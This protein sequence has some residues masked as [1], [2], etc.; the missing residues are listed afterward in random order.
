MAGMDIRD[1]STTTWGSAEGDCCVVHYLLLLYIGVA[2]WSSLLE[3]CPLPIDFDIFSFTFHFIGVSAFVP[4]LNGFAWHR[5]SPVSVLGMGGNVGKVRLLQN[6]LVMIP[7]LRRCAGTQLWGHFDRVRNV[8]PD[9]YFHQRALSFVYSA[10]LVCSK[11][12]V[13]TTG[14][15]GSS[16]ILRSSLSYRREGSVC[17]AGIQ[18]G[19]GVCWFRECHFYTVRT[20][21]GFFPIA[22]R[23]VRR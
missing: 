15:A 20:Q 18:I 1:L 5:T 22:R 4:V 7:P 11:G 12:R 10:N 6:D 13:F 17:H 9:S 19:I 2:L 23:A 21:G 16:D 8:L 3:A 14:V